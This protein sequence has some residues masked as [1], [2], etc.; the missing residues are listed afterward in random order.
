MQI[1]PDGGRATI[2]GM[3]GRRVMELLNA[4]L[5]LVDAVSTAIGIVVLWYTWMAPPRQGSALPPPRPSDAD[6]LE[7][8]VRAAALNRTSGDALT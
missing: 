2:A 8:F 5:D 6:E 1:E 4:F 3:P 7:Q